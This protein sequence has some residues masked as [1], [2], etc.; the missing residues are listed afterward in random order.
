MGVGHLIVIRW[1]EFCNCAGD[2]ECAHSF[3]FIHFFY[4]F[5]YIVIF[6]PLVTPFFLFVCMMTEEELCP[7][8]RL[9]PETVD[10][11]LSFALDDRKKKSRWAGIL[12]SVC[13]L[14]SELIPPRNVSR[15]AM[16]H[17]F[18]DRLS[19]WM[20]IDGKF[21]CR[22]AKYAR[23]DVLKHAYQQGHLRVSFTMDPG[24][25]Y[26]RLSWRFR[27]HSWKLSG[28]NG[29]PVLR[30]SK[31]LIV[32]AIKAPETIHVDQIV[33]TIEWLRLLDPNTS[34]R[35]SPSEVLE[36]A[37]ARLRFSLWMRYLPH[38]EFYHDSDSIKRLLR[39]IGRRMS[40]QDFDWTGTDHKLLPRVL[41]STNELGQVFEDVS[42]ILG[43][44]VALCRQ[45]QRLGMK[46]R[47]DLQLPFY[48]NFVFIRAIG[49]TVHRLCTSIKNTFDG[50]FGVDRDS[51]RA[52]IYCCLTLSGFGWFAI[53]RGRRHRLF[54]RAVNELHPNHIWQILLCALFNCPAERVDEL[55]IFTSALCPK[56]RIFFLDDSHFDCDPIVN[57]G[58][59]YRPDEADDDGGRPLFEYYNQ[60]IN[61]LCGHRRIQLP[62]AKFLTEWFL[63][64]N[65]QTKPVM[66]MNT[67]LFL[68]RTATAET[69]EYFYGLCEIRTP[70][71]FALESPL[72]DM[73]IRRLDF[74]DRKVIDQLVNFVVSEI[75]LS[76]RVDTRDQ[77]DFIRC[78][79]RHGF[80]WTFAHISRFR[81]LSARSVNI[82]ECTLR[83]LE[84]HVRENG[85][86]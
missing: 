67:H 8:D 34:E 69:L 40:H 7:F 65:P 21:L 3:I 11:I 50:D 56:D 13:S 2:A 73:A 12:R 6:F 68:M 81:E 1:E 43:G 10:L 77:L 60:Q 59:Q 31:A 62:V 58:L 44:D 15:T 16:I 71:L 51:D 23:L 86:E 35:L 52:F 53:D 19:P 46:L 47:H 72:V 33:D 75:I 49:E 39:R 9:P 5:F 28:S 83:L 4:F 78:T 74:T 14:W 76:P 64:H 61:V 25:R 63:S 29:Q 42:S 70:M 54:R 41:Q 24:Q 22:A 36:C 18:P 38:Q 66:R 79:F 82:A 27:R 55:S 30:W 85:T 17:L 37:A 80:P 45:W 84:F 20:R 57:I 48:R 26:S 32:S